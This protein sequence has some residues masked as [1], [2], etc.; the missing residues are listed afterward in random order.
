LVVDSGESL[1]SLLPAGVEN[2]DVE[3]F[4]LDGHFK[5]RGWSLILD[6][7]WRRISDFTADSVPNLSDHGYVL[8]T[9]Y[10]VCPQR[11]EILARWSRIVGNSGTLGVR[12][13][14]S[15]EVAG[16]IAWYF[17]GN[18]AKLVFDV[19][20]INGVPVFESRLEMIPGD[21]GWLYRTQFQLAF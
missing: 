14:S 6:Y 17:R 19:T 15:D 10:F 1:A 13:Q 3:Y 2:Y 21:A 9:G 20:H 12:D 4:T 18:N 16:G 11:L 8:Q 7:Y 5:F